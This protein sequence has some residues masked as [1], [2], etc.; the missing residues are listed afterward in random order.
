MLANRDVNLLGRYAPFRNQPNQLATSLGKCWVGKFVLFGHVY[1]AIFISCQS[2]FVSAGF[3]RISSAK[4][5]YVSSKPPVVDGEISSVKLY[6][7][8]MC[9]NLANNLGD[10]QHQV[11]Q[12]KASRFRPR[13]RTRLLP[14]PR[15]VAGQARTH[16]CRAAACHPIHGP[17][18]ESCRW[19]AGGWTI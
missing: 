5:S 3:C 16:L 12:E 6:N 1:G 18:A 2:T 17:F 15:H 14:A 11:C 8:L 9:T 13:H 19:W 10:E 7:L 4:S